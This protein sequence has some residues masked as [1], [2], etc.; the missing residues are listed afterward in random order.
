MYTK[1]LEDN[2]KNIDSDEKIYMDEIYKRLCADEEE[3]N[4]CFDMVRKTV[5]EEG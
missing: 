4:K 1:K 5:F 2:W 3:L